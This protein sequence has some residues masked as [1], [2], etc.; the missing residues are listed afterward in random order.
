[1]QINAIIFNNYLEEAILSDKFKKLRP[2]V[3]VGGVRLCIE[4][5]IDYRN[6][7]AV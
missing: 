2:S 7:A 1:M 4:A 5:L 6:T 3:K